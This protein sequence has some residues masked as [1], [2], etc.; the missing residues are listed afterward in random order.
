MEAQRGSITFTVTSRS[1][2]RT[3]AGTEGR[4]GLGKGSAERTLK[5]EN[6][7]K[8]G[9]KTDNVKTA[10]LGGT[11]QTEEGAHISDLDS[12][13]HIQKD[14]EPKPQSPNLTMKEFPHI[15]QTPGSKRG[16]RRSKE[17]VRG[18]PEEQ[19]DRSVREGDLVCL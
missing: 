7:L 9:T 17:G 18:A 8:A 2:L 5:T 14:P 11:H 6:E 1:S 10:P 12:E 13:T 19:R 3:G 4:A 15:N 16:D